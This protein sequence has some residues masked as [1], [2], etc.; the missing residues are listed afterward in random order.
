MLKPSTGS[1]IIIFGSFR[2]FSE[3]SIRLGDIEQAE[4]C[5]Q[6]AVAT[7]TS[8]TAPVAADL[9][10]AAKCGLA[11][12]FLVKGSLDQASKILDSIDADLSGATPP[13]AAILKVWLHIK[14]GDTEAAISVLKRYRLPTGFVVKSFAP[15]N[16]AK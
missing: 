8:P 2:Y 4:K 14:R 9:R 16:A 3:A 11:A 12:V 7:A 6:Q 5:V 10:V 1:L 15:N 13:N